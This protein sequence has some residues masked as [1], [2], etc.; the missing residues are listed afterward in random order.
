MFSGSEGT[1]VA[2]NV[3]K[4]TDIERALEEAVNVMVAAQSDTAKWAAAADHAK[5]HGSRLRIEQLLS[6]CAGAIC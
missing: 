1:G 4:A 2:R 3:P 6:Q 5:D